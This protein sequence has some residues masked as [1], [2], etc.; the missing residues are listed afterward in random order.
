IPRYLDADESD[1][2]ILSDTED[3]IPVL[4]QRGDAWVRQT[5]QATY[6]GVSHTVLRYRPRIE[7]MFARIERWVRIADGRSFWKSISKDNVTSLYGVTADG[8]VAD[9]DDPQR[10]FKWLLQRTYDD[11]G[12]LIVY[13]YKAE[14]RDNVPEAVHESN[15]TVGAQRYLKYIRY[16]NAT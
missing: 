3:L 6:N 5:L 10:V 2:F 16:G 7:G 4:V 12:N 8:C 15:R 1:V 11:K 13:E 9:P 14:S